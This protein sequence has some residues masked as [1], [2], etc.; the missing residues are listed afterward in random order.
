MPKFIQL[1]F[2]DTEDETQCRK[3]KPV[4]VS[5]VEEMEELFVKYFDLLSD[6]LPAATLPAVT[7]EGELEMNEDWDDTWADEH[8]QHVKRLRAHWEE[9][10]DKLFG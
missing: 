10:A 8:G 1:N 7:V 2:L 6:E 5:N 3:F 4:I 9:D